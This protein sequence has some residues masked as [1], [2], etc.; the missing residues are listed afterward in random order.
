MKLD[1]NTKVSFKFDYIFIEETSLSESVAF[2]EFASEVIEQYTKDCLNSVEIC[3]TIKSEIDYLLEAV[4]GGTCCDYIV[5]SMEVSCRTNGSTITLN[6]SVNFEFDEEE[7][8]LSDSLFGDV[9][10]TTDKLTKY[11]EDEIVEYGSIV[12]TEPLYLQLEED[13]PIRFTFTYDV[14][15]CE[16]KL[17][18]E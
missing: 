17:I 7:S 13:D 4:V 10:D 3:N 2:H 18:K 9:T 12:D 16:S 8:E 11:I 6:G 1:F 14:E 15:S 5:K